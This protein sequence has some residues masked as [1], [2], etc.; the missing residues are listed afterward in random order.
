VPAAQLSTTA[1]SSSGTH[2]LWLVCSS[3]HASQVKVT[4]DDGRNWTSVQAPAGSFTL[5]AR[6]PDSAVAVTDGSV[7]LLRPGSP[8]ARLSTLQV[9]GVV[10][11]GFTNSDTGYV[12]GADGRMWRSA[13]AG[14]TWAAYTVHQ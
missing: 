5:A 7:E 1:D 12:I 14:R 4:L 8:P 2:A 13:D 11:A 6:S 9:S 10:F 3:G